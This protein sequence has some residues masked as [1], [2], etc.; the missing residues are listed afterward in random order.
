[1]HIKRPLVPGKSKLVVGQF[2]DVVITKADAHDLW[3]NPV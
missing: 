3:A 1:V 2:A